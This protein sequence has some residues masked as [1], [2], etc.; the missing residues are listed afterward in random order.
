MT[1]IILDKI[2]PARPLRRN[3]QCIAF[4]ASAALAVAMVGQGI[5]VRLN[6]LDT[7]HYVAPLEDM[8]PAQ[9]HE[10]LQHS[11]FKYIAVVTFLVSP[12]GSNQ[13]FN[14]PP[15]WNS[16]NNKVE[17]IGG[18][19]SG[20]AVA[21]N[22]FAM[23]SGGGGGAY[24][25]QT[26]IVFVPGGTATYQI[27]VGGAAVSASGTVTSNGNNGGNT[28]FN[29]ATLGASSVGAQAGQ[30]G[31]ATLGNINGSSGG[32]ASS[33]I[34]A[35][36]FSGGNSGGNSGVALWASGGGGA[37]GPNG[38][39]VSSATPT[40]QSPSDGGNADNNAG[41]AG[42]G[43]AGG[44][45]TNAGNGGNGQEFDSSHGCG[46]GGGGCFSQVNGTFS[47]GNAGNYGGGGGGC[48][49]SSPFPT[50]LGGAGSQGLIVVTNVPATR[51]LLMN[52]IMGA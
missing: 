19:A 3:V 48:N 47:A 38:N 12:T 49:V 34:G 33:G 18:G 26:N 4:M 1:K 20:G 23:A 28:W 46:G 43:G 32:P 16:G 36:K 6:I 41:S 37:A 9:L 11:E 2:R 22:T 35:T 29:G 21:S 10:L 52:S 42:P 17:T 39:G 44:N 27:G 45:A 31:Q 50:A 40:Q 14:V 15:N 30:A 7:W 8:T 5:R 24:S 13:T 25:A 51:A